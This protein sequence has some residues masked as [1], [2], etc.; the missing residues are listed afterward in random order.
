MKNK[1]TQNSKLR[2]CIQYNNKKYLPS[3]TEN[4]EIEIVK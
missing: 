3:I 2:F 4:R 1:K